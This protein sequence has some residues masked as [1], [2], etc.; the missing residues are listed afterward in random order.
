MLNALARSRQNTWYNILSTVGLNVNVLFMHEVYF[1][2][3]KKVYGS[4]MKAIAITAAFVAKL[5]G[6]NFTVKALYEVGKP[7]SM[8]V[9]VEGTSAQVLACPY[10]RAVQ[11]EAHRAPIAGHVFASHYAER[12]QIPAAPTCCHRQSVV[13]VVAD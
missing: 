13:I 8:D 1:W 12:N 11:H 10:G 6:S 5:G 9:Q 7:S 3:K 2:R 4:F